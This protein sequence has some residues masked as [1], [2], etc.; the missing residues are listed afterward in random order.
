MPRPSGGTA[1]E[2]TR[3]GELLAIAA[4]LFAEKGFKN[5]TVRD[6]ADAAGILSGSLY[7]H[8]RLQGVDDRRD[9]VDFPGR[10]VR[11]VRRDPRQRR[12]RAHQAGARRTGVVRRD[13]QAPARGRDLPERG[14]LPRR[15]RAVRLPGR[16]QPAVAP[17]VGDP[18]GGGRALRRA[19]G[20]TST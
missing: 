20:P 6:I 19:S 8:S 4:R 18:A 12:R 3:R 17:G 15:V 5:T 9:P 13:R 2:G 7:H 16:P 14:R 11:A 1:G 10:V